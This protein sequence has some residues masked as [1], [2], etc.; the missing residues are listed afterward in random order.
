MAPTIVENAVGADE[1]SDTRTVRECL[2]VAVSISK[3]LSVAGSI[4]GQDLEAISESGVEFAENVQSDAL[5]NRKQD[6]SQREGQKDHQS[7]LDDIEREDEDDL[8]AIMD[9]LVKEAKRELQKGRARHDRRNQYSNYEVAK[10]HLLDALELGKKRRRDYFFSIED[11]IALREL[12]AE[13]YTKL[14]KFQEAE[15]EYSELTGT[16]KEG[17]VSIATYGSLCCSFAEMCQ[18]RYSLD[19]TRHREILET[20]HRYALRS[21]NIAK[22]LPGQGEWLL[23]K[24]A[25]L[26][27]DMYEKQGRL[28]HARTYRERYLARSSASLLEMNA[29][30]RS[31]D[32]ISI[33]S[34]SKSPRSWTSTS[35]SP[36]ATGSGK[37][38]DWI[39]DVKTAED[40]KTLSKDKMLELTGTIS[41]R[42]SRLSQ[43]RASSSSHT[44][45]FGKE[46]PALHYA[47][48]EGD[49]KIAQAL[50]E[51]LKRDVDEKDPN[52]ATPLLVASRRKANP[53]LPYLLEK[54]ANLL[55]KDN[56]E[57]TVLHH[58]I[59]GSGEDPGVLQLLIQK[60]AAVDAANRD[61]ETPLHFAAKYGK[62][63]LV[64]VLIEHNATLN[65]PNIDNKTPMWLAAKN[66][67]EET[68]ELLLVKN[69]YFDETYLAGTTQGVRFI[70]QEEMDR[71][72]AGLKPSKRP[73]WKR[74]SKTKSGG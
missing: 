49:L 68:V 44:S 8:I 66:G 58:S 33:S 74:R 52:R 17:R 62:K 16:A 37:D 40:V 9:D 63:S 53:V 28:S 51:K 31:P 18:A 70:L 38:E 46:E 64:G 23:K 41:R 55:E 12:L 2:D 10:N 35:T 5:S 34:S 72:R 65:A 43:P 3:K 20:W 13:V 47:S 22:D 21:L 71:R 32:A 4:Q 69:A 39:Q 61:N 45:S 48:R 60:G 15:R 19:E 11:E 42:D 6:S 36:S 67:H 50:V 14:S 26:L 57:W 24:S 25:A 73:F 30:A 1:E 7:D 54:G 59:F 29:V 27:V 56:N